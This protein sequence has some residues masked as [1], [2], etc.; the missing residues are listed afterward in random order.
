MLTVKELIELLKKFPEDWNVKFIT[1]YQ[2]EFDEE[3]IYNQL[4]E[5]WECNVYE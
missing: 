3:K 4:E 5:L 1:T 2:D